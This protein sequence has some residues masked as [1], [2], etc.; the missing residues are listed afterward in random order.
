MTIKAKITRIEPTTEYQ[1]TIY[2]QNV[3]VELPSGILIGVFDLNMLVEEDMVG[4]TKDLKISL[5]VGKSSIELREDIEPH[6]DPSGE[7]P[8]FWKNHVYFGKVMHISE[9]ERHYVMSI[10]VGDGQVLV[11]TKEETFPMPEIGSGLRVR[12][13]RS[14]LRGVG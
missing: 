10:D 9:E 4:E 6:I 1:G 14:D 2:D 7:D 13:S 3:V 8:E 5:L 11:Q 12:A